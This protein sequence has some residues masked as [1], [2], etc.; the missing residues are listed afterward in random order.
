MSAGPLKANSELPRTFN[1]GGT[2]IICS[3]F[4]GTNREY[5]GDTMGKFVKAFNEMTKG[6]LQLAGGKAA[7]LGEL[8]RAR[9]NA[10][11]G[12]CV[13]SE[14]LPYHIEYNRL[15]AR[16]KDIAAGFDYEDFAAMEQKTEDIRTLIMSAPLPEDLQSELVDAVRKLVGPEE[17]FV[18]VRSSV[19]V[20]DSPI[21]S[22][23]GMMDTFHYLKGVEEV[24]KHIKM[25]WASL[26]TVRATFNRFHKGI[27][28]DLG[29]IAPIVQRMVNPEVAGILFT[30]N[31]ITGN[32]SEM[33]VE[34]NWG[35]G[36]SVV[37]G[38]SMND[39]F[40]IDKSNLSL[41]SRKIA[42]KT[43]M[44][45]FDQGKGFGR[46]E[47][48][49]PPHQMEAPTISEDQVRDLGSVGL[50][51]EELFGFPQDIEWA[52]QSKELFIL[53]S[54]DIRNLKD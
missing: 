20:R 4:L 24:I 14:S 46:K 45:C 11:A 53:Q 29:L 17:A 32:R 9:F 42:K 48:E 52:Y 18:A 50:K 51:I 2:F 16:I 26:W 34:A 54:R 13:T 30:A 41:K 36:E 1:E 15:Q 38:K 19:A 28:H 37:S 22:F 44:V 12:F 40:L 10:P 6:D 33:V 8:T 47:M 21:S 49:V 3:G 23:P 35:L 43:I 5:R 27:A 39:F 25:C 31:P 7:N